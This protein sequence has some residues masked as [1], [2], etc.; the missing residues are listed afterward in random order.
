MY[1]G[2][3]LMV[4]FLVLG[5][6]ASLLLIAYLLHKVRRTYVAA[7][8]IRE[9]AH[10]TRKEVEWSFAQVQS[11][12]ALERRLGLPL[13]LPRMR[14][15]AGSPDFLLVLAEHISERKPMTIL[16]CSSGVSTVVAARSLQILGA[17]HVYSL[18]HEPAYADKTR[19]L[20]ARYGLAD[21]ATILD[22]P[23]VTIPSGETWYDEQSIPADLT[24]IEMLVVDG[25]P[26]S[27]GPLVRHPA[28]PRLRS[29]L[30]PECV[31]LV[32]DAGRADESE[33]LRN[34]QSRFPE[35]ERR[36]GMCEKGLAILTI[37]P[38]AVSGRRS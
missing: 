37:R 24:R 25:P 30:A 14:G 26:T 9:D 21:W 17:G 35:W 32:D 34:W 3:K 7:L 4:I 15:W 28:L 38:D 8:S 18:E 2:I 33:M 10:A 36:D 29:R 31:V 11:L 20:L 1:E 12:L 19:G 13:P 6:I 22:A 27:I 5:Q 23:L 16:E